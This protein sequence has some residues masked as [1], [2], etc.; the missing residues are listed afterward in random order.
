VLNVLISPSSAE[1]LQGDSQTITC[2][3][4][5]SPQATAITWTRTTTGGPVTLNVQGLP[6]KYSGGTV[7]NP[8]LIISN[9]AT[10]DVGSYI[11]KATN[12]VGIASSLTSVLSYKG[13]YCLPITPPLSYLKIHT[14]IQ[15]F[16]QTNMTRSFH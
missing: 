3:I 11:C 15:V 7:A 10:T 2:T 13:K 8:S 5:G 4:S 14:I 16:F 12:A 6:G 1:V 9:F